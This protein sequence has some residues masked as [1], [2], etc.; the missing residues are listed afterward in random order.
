MDAPPPISADE[1]AATP[2]SVLALIQWQAR[3]I[4]R[5]TARVEELEAEVAELKARTT[6]RSH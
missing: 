4:A 2:P 6:S 5:L 3:Q 1:L